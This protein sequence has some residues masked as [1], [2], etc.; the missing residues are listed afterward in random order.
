MS[1]AASTPTDAAPLRV[2]EV[3]RLWLPLAASWLLMGLE[4][5]LLTMAVSRLPME[6]AHLG[7]WG[8]VVFPIALVIEGPVIMLLAAS[9]ALCGDRASYARVRGFM[10]ASGA[11][12]TAV[13]AAVAFTP[14]FDVVA[15]DWLSAPADVIE[16]ARTGLRIMLPWTWAIGWRRFCQGLL[17]RNG[18]SRAVGVGTGVRLAAN[19]SVLALGVWSARFE[20]IVVGASAVAVGVVAEAL[21]AA[22]AAAPVIRERILPVEPGDAPLTRGGFLRYYLPLALTPFVTL[23]IQPLGAGAMNRLPEAELS[24][25]AFPAVH[26]LVFMTR[27]L[28]FAYNEVVVS[29]VARPG[30]PQALVRFQRWLALGT[31]GVLLLLVTTPLAGLWFERVS[32]LTPELA[33]LCTAGVAVCVLMPA[34]QVLQSY[35][36]GV[37]V[38]HGST[39]AVSEAVVVYAA[40][41]ALLLGAAVFTVDHFATRP[42]T[43]AP[44]LFGTPL[45]QIPGLLWAL[46]AFTL[47]GLTQTT[48]LYHRSHQARQ[49]FTQSA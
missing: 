34:Y 33:A 23:V 22:R 39:R 47:A 12:L 49:H 18:R 14:L 41:A 3:V 6:Q 43:E 8:G 26:G 29:L 24:I 27:S 13:H 17:I 20:G 45:P 4:L 16:P 36:Q 25:A 7:A 30:G 35:A 32:D 48:W 31:S 40:L 2:G 9:T 42:P 19:A 15:R 44:T 46:T 5:P 37:L 1:P 10:L 11:A 38:K 21:Y 28:G